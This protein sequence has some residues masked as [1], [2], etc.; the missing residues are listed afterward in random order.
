MTIVLWLIG[1]G[2]GMLLYHILFDHDRAAGTF[3]LDFTNPEKDVCK[4]D[5]EESLNTI[6]S[7]KYIWLRVKVY[8]DDDSQ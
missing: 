2:V 6:Y 7:R 1:V 5:L 4:L 8:G 3:I